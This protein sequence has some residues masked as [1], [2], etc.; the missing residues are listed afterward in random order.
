MIGYKREYDVAAEMERVA[1]ELDGNEE[2]AVELEGFFR[3]QRPLLLRAEHVQ[4]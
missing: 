2:A 3:F 4:Y 1:K